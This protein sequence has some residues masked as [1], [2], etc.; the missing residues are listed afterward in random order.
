MVSKKDSKEL[1]FSLFMI[2]IVLLMMVLTSIIWLVSPR[3][4]FIDYSGNVSLVLLKIVFITLSIFSLSLFLSIYSKKKIPFIHYFLDVI[5]KLSYPVIVRIGLFLDISED[6]IDTSF[7]DVNNTI[8]ENENIKYEK[9]EIL[10]LTSQYYQKDSCNIRINNNLNNC[11][12]C[13]QCDIGKLVKYAEK[14]GFDIEVICDKFSILKQINYYKLIIVFTSL[15]NIIQT[16]KKADN[17]RV[18]GITED[19]EKSLEDNLESIFS[20]LLKTD[21]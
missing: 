10:I 13:F 15:D 9:N 7:I 12:D 14:N 1:F 19:F 6:I 20:K 4:N 17:I 3:L 2:S 18:Y 21:E 11:K 5:I 8:I 16:I